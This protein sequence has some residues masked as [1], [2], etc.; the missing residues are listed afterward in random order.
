M[1]STDEN[2]AIE[3]KK[4]QNNSSSGNDN[5]VPEWGSFIQTL[6][7]I[8]I[9][10]IIWL[11]FYGTI[12]L[13]ITKISL[14]GVLPTNIENAPYTNLF[15]NI[16]ETIVDINIVK[17]NKKLYSSKLSFNYEE[18]VKNFYD[19]SIG[20]L[21]QFQDDPNKANFFG[22]F[23]SLIS[24]NLLSFNFNII[25]KIF[26]YLGNK[27]NETI[28]IILSPI[29]FWIL[30][31]GLYL[32]NMA[33]TFFY[34]IRLFKEFFLEKTIQ[35]NKVIWKEGNLYDPVR[36]I[37][38]ILSIFFIVIPA[39]FL[40]PIFTLMFSIFAPLFISGKVDYKNKKYSFFN[41]VLNT[42]YYKSNLFLI[43]LSILMIKPTYENLH[44]YYLVALA[45]AIVILVFKH[46]FN[47]IN[48]EEDSMLSPMT[49]TTQS[50]IKKGGG[51]FTKSKKKYKK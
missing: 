34:Q 28:L 29:I 42:I 36:W 14:A 8:I 4:K 31:V 51:K 16:A 6:I 23:W 21:K 1:D 41:F 24:F 13:Y 10:L 26:Q 48:A 50:D 25:E 3:N 44:I 19:G 7:M 32:S 46:F 30:V 40:V 11:W 17:Y 12:I 39:T 15:K 47:P 27:V 2:N 9:H 43:L 35:N 38:V 49:Q 45:L 37:F 18:I 5:D 20:F 22:N 33:M